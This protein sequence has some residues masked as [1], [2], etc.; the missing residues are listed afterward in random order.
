MG[1]L[2]AE[3]DPYT[4]RGTDNDAKTVKKDDPVTDRPSRIYR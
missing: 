2:Y 3:T 1:A 4:E